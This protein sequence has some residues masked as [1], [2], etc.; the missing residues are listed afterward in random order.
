[1]GYLYLFFFLLT[2][3]VILWKL[4]EMRHNLHIYLVN[5]RITAKTEGKWTTAWAMFRF[6]DYGLQKETTKKDNKWEN[7]ISI[8]V[9]LSIVV[10]VLASF[11]RDLVRRPSSIKQATYEY[12]AGMPTTERQPRYE[13]ADLRLPPRFKSQYFR[14]H[15]SGCVF[16]M[17]W[18]RRGLDT[19]WH[20][21]Q[22]WRPSFRKVTKFLNKQI[23]VRGK[24]K[25]QLPLIRNSPNL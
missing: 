20:V 17:M 13:N 18:P 24:D 9:T 23:L 4:K 14:R 7:K 2:T 21:S 19:L 15:S 16:V 3:Q 22:C 5:H 1:M 25:R 6:S 12:E 8:Q 10:Y 11:W